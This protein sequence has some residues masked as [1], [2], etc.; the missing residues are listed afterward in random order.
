MKKA[1]LFFGALAL[2]FTS[3]SAV[4]NAIP[5]SSVITEN[6]VKSADNMWKGKTMFFKMVPD[7]IIVSPDGKNWRNPKNFVPTWENKAG[8]LIKKEGN[9]LKQSTDNGTTWTAMAEMKWE[10]PDGTWYKFDTNWQ[11]WEI[12]ASVNNV[13]TN[14]SGK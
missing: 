14:P 13:N 3:V 11:L 10:A 7:G 8:A 5:K 1:I 4:A 9:A 2:M 6:W 12:K